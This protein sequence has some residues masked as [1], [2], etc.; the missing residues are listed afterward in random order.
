MRKFILVLGI[1]AAVKLEAQNVG[2]GT[3]APEHLLDINARMRIRGG[4]DTN[5]SAGVYFGGLIPNQTVNK[6][7]VGMNT[8]TAIAFFGYSGARWILAGDVRN[9]NV[10]IGNGTRMNRAGLTVDNKVGATNAMFGSNTRGIA[11]ESSLPGIGFNSYNNGG[12]KAIANGFAG[13][14]GVDPF[15]GGMQLSVSPVP[16]DSGTAITMNPAVFIK[17]NGNTGIGT[18]NPAARLHVADSAVVFTRNTT[19]LN[20]NANPPVQGAGVR[21]MWYPEKAAFRVG[22]VDDGTM[23]GSP[24][25]CVACP[26]NWDRENV[27]RFSFASGFNSKASGDYSIAMGSSFA[28][29][30]VSTAMGTSNAT[31]D[32][33]TAMGFGTVASGSNSTAMG[34]SSYAIGIS[35]TAMGEGSIASGGYSTAMGSFSIASGNSSTAMGTNSTASGSFS[36]AMG[37]Q[38]TA[39]SFSVVTIGLFNDILDNPSPIT[40]ALTDRLFQIGNGTAD[41]ARSNAITV[42][43]NGN[44]GLGNMN[45]PNAALQFA[46]VIANRRIVLWETANNDHEYYGF[47]IN[48][49][50]LRYQV[51]NI[52]SEHTFYAAT[53]SNSSQILFRIF[54]NGNAWLQG[55][56]T[57]NSDARLKI[58][59]HR[60]GNSLQNLQQLN[61]YTYNWVAKDRDQSLQTGLLAQELQKVYPQL[62]KEDEKG[63][64]SVNYSGLIPVLLEAIKELNSKVEILENENKEIKALAQQLLKNK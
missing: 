28:S 12:R 41:N 8:D 44:I 32:Y 4:A 36:T 59:I 42:L 13:Y 23:I 47:G 16:G 15:D 38:T 22:A 43:R 25:F 31:S 18:V 21:M 2:I 45:S 7:F 62:V 30:F 10:G 54:G 50:S 51:N 27:G 46:N 55:V 64:L 5:T 1:L 61:G 35:S 29:G 48:G 58:N 6:G 17:P 63:I 14:I 24:G 33:S 49:S 20:P 56:L 37:L 57:E 3:T 60:I 34:K 52:A 26:N 39:K 19:P 53:S 9:G 11:I 40:P